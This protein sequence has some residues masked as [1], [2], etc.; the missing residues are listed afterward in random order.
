MIDIH[1]HLLFGVD[2]GA[3]TIEESMKIVECALNEGITDIIVTPHAFSPQFNVSKMEVYGQVRLLNN[4]ID[5]AGYPI[6]LHTGQEIRLHGEVIERLRKTQ[7]IS[8]AESRYVLLELPSQSIPVYT[9]QVIQSILSMEMIPIIAHPERNRVISE[10]PSH[11]ERLIRH[12]A[13]AQVTAGSLSGHFG[14][15]IQ[16]LAILLIESNLIHTYGSDVHNLTSRPLLY[17]EGLDYLESQKLFD[18]LNILLENNERIIKNEP[19]IILEPESPRLKKHW[20]MRI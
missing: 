19:F 5:E 11:L 15:N 3:K 2:D 12:G 10:N 17:N 1:S 13:L 8:L 14:K 4:V 9:E 16:K 20:L 6:N 7:V 18:V